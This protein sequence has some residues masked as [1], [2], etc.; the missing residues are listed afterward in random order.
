MALKCSGV[1]EILERWHEHYDQSLNHPSGTVCSKLDAASSS[2]TPV[3]DICTDEPTLDKVIRAVKKLK[4]LV[5]MTSHLNSSNVP[6][7]MLLKQCIRC[8]SVSG[9]LGVSLWSGSMV[10]L[11]LCIRVRDQRMNAVV[12]ALSLFFLCQCQAKSSYTSCWS[13]YSLFYR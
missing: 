2:A 8:S 4:Q 11:S 7:H 12:T 10:S 3:I 5:V 6:F 13:I 1:E 9:G